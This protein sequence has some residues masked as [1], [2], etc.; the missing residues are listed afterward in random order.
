MKGN[1]KWLGLGGVLATATLFAMDLPAMDSGFRG[2]EQALD[3]TDLYRSCM[4]SAEKD[5]KT[6]ALR[7]G[8]GEMPRL[9]PKDAKV[10]LAAGERY[11]L[12][13]VIDIKK[14]LVFLRVDLRKQ[15]W[16]ASQT[17]LKNPFYRIEGDPAVWRKYLGRAVTVIGVSR[18]SVWNDRGR[19]VFE[20]YLEPG[21]NPV[22]ESPYGNR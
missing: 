20:I 17:R 5:C 16:L 12:S 19:T 2:I 4:L 11:A 15:P 21:P 10:E 6:W 1:L 3:R 8:G 7:G 13:G 9:L 22:I 18:Y 14:D